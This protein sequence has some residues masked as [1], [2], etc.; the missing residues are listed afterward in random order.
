MKLIIDK[1]SYLTLVDFKEAPEVLS[2]IE[3]NR[4]YLRKWLGWLDM[5]QSVTDLSRFI[6]T[7]KKE[8]EAKKGLST[9]IWHKGEAVGIM[10]LKAV[11][12]TNKKAEIGYWVGEEHRGQGIAKKA[13]KAMLH[14]A[15]NEW[16]LN[17]VE[18]RCATKN[19]AS[20][21][22]PIY[23]GFQQEGILRENEWL[24]DHFVDHVVFSILKKDWIKGLQK[25]PS[26]R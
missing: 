9:F 13:C 2:L 14:F 23:L 10:H 21:A 18:I 16:D 12:P 5:T 7:C 3:R 8:F 17:R 1:D 19:K 20:Q 26:Q 11:N 6:E 25:E 22:I 4:R 24:Y 15:F